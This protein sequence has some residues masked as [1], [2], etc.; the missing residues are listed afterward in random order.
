MEDAGRGAIHNWRSWFVHARALAEKAEIVII[1]TIALY[2]IP[3]RSIEKRFRQRVKEE[4]TH[5]VDSQRQDYVHGAR[6]SWAAG[7]TEDRLWEKK[8]LRWV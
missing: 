6:R 5:Y 3:S 7:F 2:P 4:I 1:K 8:Q